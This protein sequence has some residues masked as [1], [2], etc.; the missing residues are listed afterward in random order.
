MYHFHCEHIVVYFILCRKLNGANM[1]RPLYLILLLGFTISLSLC[2]NVDTRLP[3]SYSLGAGKQGYF[4]GYSVAL[5]RA[6]GKNW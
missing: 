5:H 6:D 2:F 1:T 3:Y 4:F